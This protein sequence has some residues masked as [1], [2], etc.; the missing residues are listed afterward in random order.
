VAEADR[1]IAKNQAHEP[2]D[3]VDA[4]PINENLFL[5]A[6]LDGLEDELNDLDLDDLDDS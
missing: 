1:L 3:T 6:D 5:D 4:A 2:T